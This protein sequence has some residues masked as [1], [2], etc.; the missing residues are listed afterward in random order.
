M[1][2]EFLIFVSI[3]LLMACNGIEKNSMS[4]SKNNDSIYIEEGTST[5]GMTI[6]VINNQENS[7]VKQNDA[8]NINERGSIRIG[9]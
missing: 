9:N 7:R 5:R 4:S 3:F 2:S 6:K 8:I 1:M